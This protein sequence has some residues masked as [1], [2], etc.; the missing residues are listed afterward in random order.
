MGKWSLKKQE[1][2]GT[3]RFDGASYV[4]REVYD[5]IHPFVIAKMIVL[6]QDL[7]QANNGMDYLQVFE[8][9]NGETIYFIDQLNDEM[10]KDCTQEDNYFT[11]LF[12]WEY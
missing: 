4:T 12:S 5:T 8:N 7:V 10:K 9:E 6:I 11:I 2:P 1:R 3:Y